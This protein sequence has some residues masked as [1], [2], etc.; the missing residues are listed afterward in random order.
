VSEKARP[1]RFDETAKGL[2]IA[3]ASPGEQVM[4]VDR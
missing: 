2:L 1:V 4:L 3:A